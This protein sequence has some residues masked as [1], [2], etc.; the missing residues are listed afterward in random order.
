MDSSCPPR[1]ASYRCGWIMCNQIGLGVQGFLAATS[2]SGDMRICGKCLV[3][4]LPTNCD[5]EFQPDMK[6]ETFLNP[7]TTLSMSHV[8]HLFSSR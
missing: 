2:T 6:S 1:Q 8:G 4:S 3:L 7:D 5:P